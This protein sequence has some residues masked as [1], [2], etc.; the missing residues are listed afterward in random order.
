MPYVD[1]LKALCKQHH[2]IMSGTKAEIIARL[3]AHNINPADAD[4]LPHNSNTPPAPDTV[5]Y[6]L[7]TPEVAR[8][9]P[10]ITEELISRKFKTGR[11]KR[12]LNYFRT[13]G[14]VRKMQ[15]T[16]E[17]ESTV[18]RVA[19]RHSMRPNAKQMHGRATFKSDGTIATSCEIGCKY[20]Y[21]SEMKCT[22]RL[23]WGAQCACEV[24]C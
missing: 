7:L 4:A 16:K 3:I 10:Q 12:A 19:M 23:K 14:W 15:Y 8:T 5:Q 2:I 18:I 11:K 24:V 1:Q 9:L 6:S 20:R 22:V 13:P 17:G 21:V